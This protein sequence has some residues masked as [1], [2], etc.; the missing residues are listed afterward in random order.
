MLKKLVSVMW[1]LCHPIHALQT[2]RRWVR[3]PKSEHPWIFIVGAPRSGTTLMKTLLVA[4]SQ[5]AGTD[6]ESTGIFR[7]R[8]LESYCPSDLDAGSMTAIRRE[9]DGI[10]SLFDRVAEAVMRKRGATGFVDKLTVQRWRLKFVARHFP[11]A[12]FICIVRDGRD[13]LCSAQRHPNVSQSDSVAG[14]A[15]YWKFCV[16]TPASIIDDVRMAMVRYEDL[17]ADPEP[18]LERLMAFVEHPFEVSQIDPSVYSAT[19]T[20]K[21]REVH[22]NLARNINSQSQQRWRTDLPGADVAEFESVAGAA[23]QTLGYQLSAHVADGYS[24]EN[25]AFEVDSTRGAN[26]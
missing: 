6:Y 7:M 3:N 23:L 5:L 1:P 13:C 19:S 21:K 8:D 14:F 25:A 17:T 2:A 12:R 18:T 10:V 26:S 15:K 4:H 16:E 9:T 24:N 11:N 22:K 20:M